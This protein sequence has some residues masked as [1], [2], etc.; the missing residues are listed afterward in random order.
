MSSLQVRA[1]TLLLISLYLSLNTAL[2][3]SVKHALGAYGFGFPVL[4]TASHMSFS[5]LALT[6]VMLTS[7][8]RNKHGET[9][10]KQWKGLVVIGVL[11]AAS[12]ALNNTSLVSMTLTLNQIVRCAPAREKAPA[13]TCVARWAAQAV[14]A[15]TFCQPVSFPCYQTDK[16]TQ[17]FH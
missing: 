16:P 15:T 13:S 1:R 2:N 17:P 6:P 7:A 14:S 11:M 4:L 10:R 12:I 3:L 9:V 5:F 8:H